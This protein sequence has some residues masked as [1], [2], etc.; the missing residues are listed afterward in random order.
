MHIQVQQGYEGDVFI[1]A[2]EITVLGRNKLAQAANR[3]EEVRRVEERGRKGR[4]ERRRP[5]GRV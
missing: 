5:A 2:V 4:P 3:L 1:D